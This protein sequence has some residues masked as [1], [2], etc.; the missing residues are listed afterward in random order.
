MKEKPILFSSSMIRAIM[1][2]RKCQTRR[3]VKPSKGV[4]PNEGDMKAFSKHKLLYLW[5][6]PYQVGQVL[7][8]RE[9]FTKDGATIY[10]KANEHEERI[11]ERRGLKW[12][13]SIFMPKKYCRLRLKVTDVRVERIQDIS[14]DDAIAEGIQKVENRFCIDSENST[15]ISAKLAFRFLWGSINKSRGFGW[16]SNPFVFVI[17]F[18]KL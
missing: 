6:C 14:E 3:V 10:Y 8:V 15:Y 7:W 4:Y 17:E 16:S 2:K 9:T 18:E 5:G 12:K 13:P 1:D 11:A